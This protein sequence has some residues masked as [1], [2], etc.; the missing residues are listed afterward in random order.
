MHFE[1]LVLKLPLNSQIVF[2]TF[3]FVGWYYCVVFHFLLAEPSQLFL[4]FIDFRLHPG[5]RIQLEV[6]LVCTEV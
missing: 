2:C 5:R 6:A 3:V 1:Q 4:Q